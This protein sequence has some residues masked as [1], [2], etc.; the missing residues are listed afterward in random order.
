MIGHLWARHRWLLLGFLV[1]SALA[2]VFTAR[3]LVLAAYWSEHRDEAIAGWMTPGYVGHSWNVP[4]EVVGA[5]LGLRR[6]DGARRLTLTEIA[7][8]QG[9]PVADL[10]RDLETAIAAFR[11][12]P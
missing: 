1:A 3:A 6:E 8:A 9:V 10:A 11:G 2:L 5:A 7:A 4:P 12:A